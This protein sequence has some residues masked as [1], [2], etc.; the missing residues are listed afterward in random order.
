MFFSTVSIYKES[1]QSRVKSDLTDTYQ[2]SPAPLI[3]SENAGCKRVYH[4]LGQ[5]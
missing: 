1:G 4:T 3:Q 5:E 2:Y